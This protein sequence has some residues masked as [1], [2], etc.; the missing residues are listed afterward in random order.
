[1]NIKA[2]FKFIDSP[3]VTALIKEAVE[4]IKNNK[5]LGFDIETTGKWNGAKYR[6][7]GLDP[8]MSNVIMIQIGTKDVQYVIDTRKVDPTPILK[9]LV[10]KKVV[11][12]NLKF[13]YV[14]ILE[15]YGLRLKD[16]YDTQ[17]Y[18]ELADPDKK[19]FT[20][21]K[22]TADYYLNYKMNKTIRAEFLSIRDSPFTE[23]QIEYGALDVII[24]LLIKEEQEKIIRKKRQEKIVSLENKFLMVLADIEHTGMQF[25]KKR[26]LEL[27]VEAEEEYY[28]KLQ[29]FEEFVYDNFPQVRDSQMDLFST[30]KKT[31]VEWNS[32]K[33]VIKFFKELDI[34]P[35]AKSKTT[36]KVSYTVS[37]KELKTV[38]TDNSLSELNRKLIKNF[39]KL[40][41]FA[42]KVSNFG[43]KFTD[44]IH[45]I[46]GRVHS[47]YKQI[48]KTGRI[49]SKNP[50]LQNIPGEKAYRA[51]FDA[52]V[53]YNI[54]NADYSG[55]EQIVLANKSK[56]K[57]L[58]SFYK[59][60]N[61]DMHSFIASKI[62]KV[63]MQ[64][65]IDAKDDK[66]D[67]KELT[68]RQKELLKYRQYAKA[69]GFAINYGGT[70]FTIAKNLG[71]PAEVGDDVYNK[72]F[73]AFP[74]LSNY[75]NTQKAKAAAT[76]TVVIDPLTN[77]TYEYK[78]KEELLSGSPRQRERHKIQIGKYALN[79][80]IQ[81]TA[82]LITKVACILLREHMLENDL[83]DSYKITNLVHDE[84]NIE[85]KSEAAEQAAEDLQRCM[86]Q[87][88][89]Y[90]CKII[91]LKATAKI[92]TYWAH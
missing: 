75:F 66:E 38:L 82:G 35:Q 44:Y 62:Y 90:W 32:S 8:R 84:I 17:L 4:F 24:P 68:E 85:S 30:S 31:I 42:Q 13:E 48:L 58:I 33:Q 39:I 1:M 36:G 15:S 83:Y 89:T 5:V 51:C 67:N 81:G 65:I 2:N 87:A 49:S 12:H 40:G 45:P 60:G 80:P 47:K 10:H 61:T 43:V 77:R 7:E 76:G 73:E 71:I 55:Q 78:Y 41:E 74:G 26:W 28:Q 21:L 29:D 69:A 50:N 64:E 88:G 86:E 63:E 59:E 6:K 53:G 18:E 11:G 25:N 20:S 46:T 70:G 91:K 27:A 72:Y 54:V 9:E 3:S 19:S 14:H 22:D 92:G 56:D 52:P 57:D 37:S 16:V 79:Y 34:C 23:E